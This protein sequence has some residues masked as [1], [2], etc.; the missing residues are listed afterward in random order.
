MPEL[1]LPM[2][3]SPAWQRALEKGGTPEFLQENY[4]WSDLL[5]TSG[6]PEC[7][8]PLPSYRHAGH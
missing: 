8:L 6:L 3:C 1:H 5:E 7:L 2:I 4:L